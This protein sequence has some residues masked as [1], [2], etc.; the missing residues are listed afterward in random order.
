MKKIIFFIMTVLL[1]F[2]LYGCSS[3]ETKLIFSKCETFMNDFK[4]GN[5]DEIEKNMVLSGL[6]NPMPN[7]KDGIFQHMMD[8]MEYEVESIEEYGPKS[9][10]A[11]VIVRNIDI[12]ELLA[13][14]P[15]NVSSK[16]EAKKEIIKLM[17]QIELKDYKAELY[18]IKYTDEYEISMSYT[19]INAL[20]GGL[21]T[22]VEEEIL[23][24]V[25]QHE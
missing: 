5:W 15:K 20:T 21:H 16:E 18:F 1:S 19:F 22:F 24:E 25:N 8:R 6:T 10:Q 14:I 11:N 13:R 7:V 3:G 23:K 4:E 12:K 9:Y 17:N 2:H